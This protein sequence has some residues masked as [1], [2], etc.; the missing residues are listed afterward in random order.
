MIHLTIAAP[1]GIDSLFFSFVQRLAVQN[2]HPC[3]DPPAEEFDAEEPELWIE[4]LA[5]SSRHHFVIGYRYPPS[6]WPQLVSHSTTVA[7]LVDGDGIARQVELIQRQEQDKSE[8]KEIEQCLQEIRHAVDSMVGLIEWLLDEANPTRLLP[9]EMAFQTDAGEAFRRV[10]RFYQE[11]G[12]AI[13]ASCWQAF[14]KEAQPLLDQIQP[15]S[16]DVRL[17]IQRLLSLEATTPTM[18][19]AVEA[20]FGDEG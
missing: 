16:M 13:C 8:G 3:V 18:L 2:G 7:V 17:A 5:R 20:L 11:A 4:T 14:S 10:E 15:A 6:Y 1:L 12:V 19:K 9:P